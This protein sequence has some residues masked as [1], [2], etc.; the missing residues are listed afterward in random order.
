[1]VVSCIAFICN[2]ELPFIVYSENYYWTAQTVHT[3]QITRCLQLRFR[4]DRRTFLCSAVDFFLFPLKK[5]AEHFSKIFTSQFYDTYRC[6]TCVQNARY[7]P[8][9][10]HCSHYQCPTGVQNLTILTC[11]STLQ[12]LPVPNWCT[13][14]HDTYLLI[15]IAA[16]T[17]VQPVYRT[18]RVCSLFLAIHTQSGVTRIKQEMIRGASQSCFPGTITIS[19]LQ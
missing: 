11:W 9:D 12:P 7:L 18:S 14:P 13:E 15:N 10:Q 4:P 3:Q 2:T 6:P 5:V 16:I 1:M 8:A 17:G 19:T